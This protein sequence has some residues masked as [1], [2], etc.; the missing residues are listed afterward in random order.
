LQQPTAYRLR[1]VIAAINRGYGYRRVLLPVPVRPILA[2]LQI[3]EKLPA[4]RLPITSTN[5]KGLTQAAAQDPSSDF[6]QFG[7]PE[8]PLAALVDRAAQAHSTP[9]RN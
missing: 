1:D 4:P 2:L 7:Y 9:E 8:E 5:V 3:V 6:A